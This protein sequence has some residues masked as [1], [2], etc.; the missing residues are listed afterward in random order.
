MAVI[1]DETRQKVKE[2]VCEI[3]EVEPGEVTDISL[4][5]EE[6]DADSMRA[7]EIL[8]ALELSF[9]VTIPQPEIQRMVNMSGIYDVLEERF[10][11]ATS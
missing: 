2:I 3:L 6:H 10:A 5:M 11:A 9:K 7:I 4:F 1:T 8:A